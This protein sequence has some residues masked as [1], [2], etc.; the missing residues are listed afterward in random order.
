VFLLVSQAWWA[1]PFLLAAVP[2]TIGAATG[3]AV[4]TSAVGVSPG[5]DPRRR[6]GP[7]DANGNISLHVWV[8]ILSTAVAVAP[9]G[10]MIVWAAINPSPVVGWLAAGVGVANG[11]AAAWLLGSIAIGYLRTRMGDVFSRIR[12][13][14]VFT[15]D[16]S[17]GML[18]WIAQATLEG[19]QKLQANKQKQREQKLARLG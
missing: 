6:V 5:V 18:G 15:E 4:L 10:L 7:N 3:A 12:Y 13:G 11:V 9:T 16:G 2:A 17:A 19:E 8:V 14:R 1:L